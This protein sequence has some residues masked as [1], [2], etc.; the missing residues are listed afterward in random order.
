MVSFT[1]GKISDPLW[2]HCGWSWQ[3]CQNFGFSAHLARDMER[4][5]RQCESTGLL[6][7]INIAR[8]MCQSIPTNNGWCWNRVGLLQNFRIFWSAIRRRPSRDL[9]TPVE[10]VLLKHPKPPRRTSPPTFVSLKTSC[11]FI[12]DF[13]ILTS[14][15]KNCPAQNLST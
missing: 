3:C 6:G 4:L 13:R 10:G 5:R 14:T 7:T 12:A 2:M 9:N 8:G 15:I 11:C 1:Q